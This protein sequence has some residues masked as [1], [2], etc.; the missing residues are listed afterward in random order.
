MRDLYVKIPGYK[1]NRINASY[2]YGGKDLLIDT[3]KTNFD[4]DIDGTVE[5]DFNG[6]IDV[7]DALEGIDLEI[8]EEE[9]PYINGCIGELNL[10][11]GNDYYENYLTQSGLQTLN[12]TQALAYSRIRHIGNGILIE[13]LGKELF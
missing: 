3:L 4:L 7:I 11:N 9:L 13:R 12:G 10:L 8:N 6:F 2:K 5:I 1:D